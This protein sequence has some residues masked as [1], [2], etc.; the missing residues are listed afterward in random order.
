MSLL[1]H[2]DI[3]HDK[4]S[5]ILSKGEHKKTDEL[6]LVNPNVKVPAIKVGDWCLFEGWSI[7]RFICD[8]YLPEDNTLYPRDPVKRLRVD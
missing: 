3:P 8:T 5:Y 4:S 1:A 2:C 6:K 7:A